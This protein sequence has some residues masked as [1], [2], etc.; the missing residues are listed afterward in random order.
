MRV[1]PR[2]SVVSICGEELQGLV[3]HVHRHIAHASDSALVPRTLKRWEM[4]TLHQHV[5]G[6]GGGRDLKGVD[7]L[8]GL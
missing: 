2:G 6:D 8:S 1:Y 4:Q 5:D 7:F 3:L